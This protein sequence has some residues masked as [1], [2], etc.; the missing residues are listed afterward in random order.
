MS[1]AQ[2][3]AQSQV[4]LATELRI[5]GNDYHETHYHN[6]DI[7]KLLAVEPVAKLNKRALGSEKIFRRRFKFDAPLEQRADVIAIKTIYDF[8]DIELRILKW[9]GLLKANKGQ[10][11]SLTASHALVFFGLIEFLCAPLPFLI[12]FLCTF[13]QPHSAGLQALFQSTV[14]G[15]IAFGLTASIYYAAFL[16][17]RLLKQRGFKIG[18]KFV[19]PTATVA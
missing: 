11:T 9:A 3:K 14:T 13:L 5:A 1:H 19:L 16:P 4:N 2:P 17:L 18:E 8:T 6:T 10:P 12:L 7:K 15:V